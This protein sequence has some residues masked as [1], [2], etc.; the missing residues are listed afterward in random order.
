MKLLS[1]ATLLL[2]SACG[3]R[4]RDVDFSS[5]A[6]LTAAERAAQSRLTA[7]V[8]ADRRG[9]A[10]VINARLRERYANAKAACE[11][12]TLRL[13]SSTLCPPRPPDFVTV[14]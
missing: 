11:A 8:L 9:R 13:A 2:L 12:M 5:A 6:P 10:A 1:L 4:G 14:P 3:D 7:A